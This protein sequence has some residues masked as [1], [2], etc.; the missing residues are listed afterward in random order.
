MG[1]RST[2]AAKAIIVSRAVTLASQDGQHLF[3]AWGR[4]VGLSNTLHLSG[5]RSELS[6]SGDIT[7]GTSLFY[8]N[9]VKTRAIKRKIC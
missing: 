6:P 5:D 2:T 1:I 7:E 8:E 9:S 4:F 3:L